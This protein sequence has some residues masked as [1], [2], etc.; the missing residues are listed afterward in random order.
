MKKHTTALVVRFNEVDSYHVAWHGHYVAWME[1]GRNDLAG[2]FGL[3]AR[4]LTEAGYLGPVVGLEVKYLHPARFKDQ[5]TVCTT[6][7]LCETAMLMFNNEILDSNGRVLA[8]GSTTHALTDLQG[9]L[10]FRIPDVIAERVQRMTEWL[11]SP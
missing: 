10:Q 2:R 8:T 3:D 6:L 11:E 1:V 9:V 5:I 7:R 4:Q